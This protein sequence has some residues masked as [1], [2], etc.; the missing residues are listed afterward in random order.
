MY[1]AVVA[2]L[3][4]ALTIEGSPLVSFV[5]AAV[6]AVLFQPLRGRLQ[7]VAN[8]MTYGSRDDPQRAVSSLASRLDD[9]LTPGEALPALVSS[10]REAM[11]SPYASITAPDGTE[12]AASGMPPTPAGLVVVPLT[13]HG[14]VLGALHL[15]PRAPG[16]EY[17]SRDRHLLGELT[18]LAASAVEAIRL[19]EQTARLATDLQG[20]RERLVAAREEE[21]RR[22]RRDLHDGLGPMLAGQVMKIESAR[23]LVRDQPQRADMML[24]DALEG[25]VDAV[26][27]VRRVAHDLR[28]PAL[29]E[30][31]LAGAVRRLADGLAAHRLDVQITVDDLPSLPAAVE[32]A[33]YY[34][35]GEALTNVARHSGAGSAVVA[36]R[37]LGGELKVSVR[38]DGCGPGT[39]TPAG[40]GTESMRE[41][42]RELGGD[43]AVTAA[44]ERG[45]L[46]SANLPCEG[47]GE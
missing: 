18:S 39:A 21:R 30:L 6:I 35:V 12:L 41:R 10:V 44:A 2:W 42:A 28:P 7:R 46:V 36:L 38:D 43:C 11:R 22:L 19:R 23:D 26:A 17:D 14:E 40:V 13:R 27:E 47:L 16:E 45:T 20:S 3:G 32:V 33:A 24:G 9:A 31:G 1:A 29:D 5:A 8:R 15:A 37:V 4:T 34:I 25:M